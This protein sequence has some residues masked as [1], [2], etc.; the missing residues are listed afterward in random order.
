MHANIRLN[1]GVFREGKTRFGTGAAALPKADSMLVN[2]G[3]TLGSI[4]ARAYG[5]NTAENRRKIQSANG[6]LTGTIR[7]PR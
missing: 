3:E 7:I 4:T 2:E 6:S 5:A 1:N